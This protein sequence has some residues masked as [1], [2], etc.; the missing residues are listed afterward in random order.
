ME[1]SFSSIRS[2][3]TYVLL[4]VVN[5][6]G[7]QAA[8]PEETLISLTLKREKTEMSLDPEQQSSNVNG[9][10]NSHVPRWAACCPSTQTG[11]G[12]C[13]SVHSH[14]RSGTGPTGDGHGART[15]TKPLRQPSGTNQTSKQGVNLVSIPL[16]VSQRNIHILPSYS[17]H[18]RNRSYLCLGEGKVVARER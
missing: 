6:L 10:Y 15:G 4:L 17:M 1:E 9:F 5:E 11:A 16:S 7:L 18:A 12:E 3:P 13:G 14:K 2:S 8:V